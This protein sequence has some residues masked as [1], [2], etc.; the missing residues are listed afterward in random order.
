MNH[1]PVEK[2]LF[3]IDKYAEATQLDISTNTNF[4]FEGM[5]FAGDLFLVLYF[6]HNYILT[7]YIHT[8]FHFLK[9]SL[10]NQLT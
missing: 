3:L 7:C 5:A 10:I 8:S 1:P 4:G 2:P 9:H 6:F